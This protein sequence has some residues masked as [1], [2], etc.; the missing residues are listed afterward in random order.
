MMDESQVQRIM[1]NPNFKQMAQKKGS[2]GMI[3][4]VITL[5]VWFS[6]LLLVGMNPAMFAAPMFE[7]SM[8]TVGFYVGV[9]IM[10]FVVIITAIYVSKANGEFDNLTRKVIDDINNGKI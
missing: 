3:F 6:Y 4:T 9:G 1:N 10:I 7:G 2:I 8:T 5:I